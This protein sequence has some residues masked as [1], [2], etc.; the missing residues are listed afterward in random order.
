M[1]E[2]PYS[3]E[4]SLRS[5]GTHRHIP[6]DGVLYNNFLHVPSALKLEEQISIIFGEDS[7]LEKR[8]Q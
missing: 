6:E 7:R 1:I 8:L 2:A 5:T 4:T 3:S